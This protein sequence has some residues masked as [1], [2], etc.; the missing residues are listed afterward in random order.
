MRRKAARD[1]EAPD[2]RGAGGIGRGGAGDGGRRRR[3]ALLAGAALL[4]AVAAGV[5]LAGDEGGPSGTAPDGPEAPT[6][7]PTSPPPQDDFTHPAFVLPPRPVPPRHVVATQGPTE[8]SA[9]YVLVTWDRSDPRAVGYEVLRNGAVIGTTE[10]ADEM[11]A[12]DDLAFTDRKV[13][14][15]VAYAYQVRA[16][17]PGGQR[18]EPSVEHRLRVRSDAQVG[19][20]RVFEVERYPGSD[21]ARAQAAVNAAIAAGGG[22]VRFGPRSYTFDRPLRVTEADNVVLRGAGMDRTFL[23]PRFSGEKE[24]CGQGGQLVVFSG[25]QTPLDVR[26]VAPV[27]VGERTARVSSVAGLAPGQRL[28]FFEEPAVSEPSPQALTRA[29]VRQDPGTGEDERHRWDANEIVAVD[30]AARSLTFKY[31]F[32]QTFAANLRLEWL[33]RGNGNGIELLTVEGRTSEEQTHYRLLELK[34]QADFTVADVQAR[35]ANRNLLFVHGY[36][37]KVV[38]FRGPFGDPGGDIDDSCRYKIS[39]W[40]SANFTFVGGRMG[41]TDHEKNT[42]LISIQRA[43]RVLVRHSRFGRSHTYAFNEHGFGS[44]HYIFENNWVS[45]GPNATKGAVLLGNESWGFAGPGIIRNNRF[46]GNSRD[47]LMLENSYE[48]RVVDN[49]MIGT[50]GRVVEGW[51]WAAPG[52]RPELH[53]SIRW[54]IARNTV[55][56]GRGDGI[57][58]GE[59]GRSAYP[60]VGVRDVII[61]ANRLEVEGQAIRLAGD[62]AATDRFQVSANVGNST[63]VVP[64][65]EPGDYWAG[66][67]DGRSFGAPVPV[68]WAE[69][70]F[71]WEPFDVGTT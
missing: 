66:N 27:A 63:Y 44:R 19:S 49:V 68:P 34:P 39:V 56:E 46:R 1:G 20:G 22:V 38:G 21:V 2:G 12:W 37:V 26:L 6:P 61:T 17:L 4:V 48:V 18:S 70:S 15:G 25:R 10:V 3:P 69:T 60:Y 14:P 16:R 11:D 54:A 5:L 47:V 30:A 65:L 13:R 59:P 52:M 7:R 71:G 50:F 55:V 40:R 28:V 36:D 64:E 62:A 23:R 51:G 9:L 67:A 42:S 33:E 43:Q 58:L 45:V 24:S 41:S 57:V 32:S 29:G 35:W 31:P 53:G 8:R